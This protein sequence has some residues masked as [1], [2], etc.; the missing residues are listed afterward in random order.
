MPVFLKRDPLLDVTAVSNVFLLEY[1]PKA[2]EGFTKAYL[3]GLMQ[4]G[5]PGAQAAGLD[6]AGVLGIEEAEL[7]RAFAYWQA[8]GLVRV[9]SDDPLTVE[10]LRAGASSGLASGDAPRKYASLVAALQDVAG[11]RMFSGHELA[12]IY[13]W[14]ETYRFEEATAVLC[15]KDCLARHGARAKLWQMNA[16][17]KRWADAGVVTPEEAERFL[18]LEQ[19]RCAGAQRILR[20]WKRSRAATEDE[21]ALYVKWTEEWGFDESVIFDACAEMTSAAQPSFRY[22]DTILQTYRLNGAVTAE[23]AAEL[24]RARDAADEFARMLF[25]RAEIRRAPTLAQREQIETWHD[26]WHMG[27]ELLFHAADESRTAPQPFQQIKK[28]VSA[29]HDAGVAT[30]SAAQQFEQQRTSAPA[31]QQRKPRLAKAHNHH[32][33]AYSDEELAKIGIDLLED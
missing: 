18:A 15:V 16:A 27:A 25:E 14:I 5:A 9:I 12:E 4:T 8:A 28:L 33:R 22:L 19:Q 32:E 21:L 17:A 2:P 20:R 31:A 24:R 26:R 7:A 1:M 3:L 6:V 10:Y 29:W 13:D 23:A 11:T 30:V